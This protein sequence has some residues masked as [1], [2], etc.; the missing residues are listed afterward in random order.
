MIG[1]NRYTELITV[2]KTLDENGNVALSD[3]LVLQRYLIDRS[4]YATLTPQSCLWARRYD[5]NDYLTF[6]LRNGTLDNVDKDLDLLDCFLK[7]PS[8]VAVG[9]E[10]K[11]SIT[12]V[13][14]AIN[15]TTILP[16]RV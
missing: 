2:N 15:R 9:L 3:P 8:V 6:I 16:Q 11:D 1:N 7:G 14:N 4:Q 5:P 12:K 13:L 10:V